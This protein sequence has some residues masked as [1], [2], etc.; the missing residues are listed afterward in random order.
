ME[1]MESIVNGKDPNS[2]ETPVKK[3]SLNTEKKI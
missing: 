1:K 2:K 3:V